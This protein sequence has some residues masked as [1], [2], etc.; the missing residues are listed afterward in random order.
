M[1]PTTNFGCYNSTTT[2]DLVNKALTA[3][4]QSTA[5]TDWHQADVQV[6]KDAVIVPFTNQNTPAL[7]VDPGEERDLVLDQPAVR[8]DSALAQPEHALSKRDTSVAW[9]PIGG[10]ATAELR[11]Q[12]RTIED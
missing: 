7:Q 6:M 8:P 3:T 10:Q 5:A 4:S 11:S 9:P 2:K 12:L 1:N